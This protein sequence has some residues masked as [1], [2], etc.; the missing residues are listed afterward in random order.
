M[1]KMVSFMVAMM[2]VVM[3]MTVSYADW[4]G[5]VFYKVREY[6]ENNGLDIYFNNEVNE[7][8]IYMTYG[9]MDLTNMSKYMESEIDESMLNNISDWFSDWYKEKLEEYYPEYGKI[10]IDFWLYDI[11]EDVNIYR[12]VV[13]AEND[14]VDF[15]DGEQQEVMALVAIG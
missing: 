13:I 8:G 11:Y 5:E 3:F 14:L 1:K 15:I 2:A 9:Y 6:V 12:L 7:D 10:Y 4:N